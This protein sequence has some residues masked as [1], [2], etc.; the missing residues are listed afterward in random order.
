MK[1]VVPAAR[2]CAEWP[3]VWLSPIATLLDDPAATDILII[4][5]NMF[6]SGAMARLK[7]L[8]LTMPSEECWVKSA[9]VAARR[10]KVSE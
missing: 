1:A 9:I 8:F 10:A 2:K 4:V 7:N 6:M 3:K 5:A